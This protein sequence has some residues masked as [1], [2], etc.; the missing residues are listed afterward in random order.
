MKKK[1]EDQPSALPK[2]L[3]LIGL[4]VLIAAGVVAYYF[5]GRGEEDDGGGTGGG[6]G[7]GGISTDTA[8]L[9][10]ENKSRIDTL[11]NEAVAYKSLASRADKLSAAEVYSDQNQQ[12]SLGDFVAFSGAQNTSGPEP[13]VIDGTTITLKGPNRRY[14]VNFGSGAAAYPTGNARLSWKLNDELVPGGEYWIFDTHSTLYSGG[15]ATEYG[16]Y[17][18]ISFVVDTTGADDVLSLEVTNRDSPNFVLR[19]PRLFVTEIL[20]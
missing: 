16:S 20:V 11:Q 14:L 19:Q 7:G 3:L 10:Q 9:A 6:T 13:P 17:V 8:A 4:F 12:L 15:G 5:I 2:V 1:Q 18:Q